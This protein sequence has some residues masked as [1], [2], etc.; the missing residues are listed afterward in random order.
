MQFARGLTAVVY[1]AW[2]TV[3]SVQG[4]FPSGSLVNEYQDE[5]SDIDLGIA[6]GNSA[7]AFNNAFTF[8][9]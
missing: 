5:Y 9:T 7:K 3:S 1:Q 6:N 8:E 4:A 2:K